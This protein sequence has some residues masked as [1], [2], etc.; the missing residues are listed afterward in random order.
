MAYPPPSCL[1][2]CV[3][4][5][6]LTCPR[7]A[8][9]TCATATGGCSIP[10]CPEVQGVD[11]RPSVLGTLGQASCQCLAVPPHRFLA[12]SICF[13]VHETLCAKRTLPHRNKQWRRLVGGYC[14]G[15]GTSPPKHDAPA[16]VTLQLRGGSDSAN[17]LDDPGRVGQE[18]KP[19]RWETADGGE[20]GLLVDPLEAEDY[21]LFGD[22]VDEATRQEIISNVAYPPYPE[23]PGPEVFSGD[24]LDDALRFDETGA[25]LDDRDEESWAAAAAAVRAGA[26]AAVPGDRS[27]DDFSFTSHPAYQ[28]GARR[29]AADEGGGRMQ[30]ETI[31]GQ[32]RVIGAATA[33][34]SASYSGRSLAR[35]GTLFGHASLASTSEFPVSSCRAPSILPPPLPACPVAP[36]RQ[37]PFLPLLSPPHANLIHVSISQ[38]PMGP[39][40]LLL[41]T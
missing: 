10:C 6:V 25:E 11:A 1:G 18:Y 40:M 19:L 34:N 41:T 35:G 29:D 32:A 16:L 5:G 4:I 21:G 12:R 15:G 8:C 13:N 23:V 22:R 2:L 38:H 39:G 14:V 27:A 36:S 30:D 3:L 7:L 20:E 26:P 33:Y 17:S 28:P 24:L 9:R 37:P 31:D